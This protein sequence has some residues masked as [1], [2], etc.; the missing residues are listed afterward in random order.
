M[1]G[2]ISEGVTGP[3]G[4]ITP[5]A[6]PFWSLGGLR[7]FGCIEDTFHGVME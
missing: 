2:W 5:T 4:A 1:P 3:A 7:L 6:S